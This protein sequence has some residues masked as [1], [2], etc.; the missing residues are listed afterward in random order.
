MRDN[1]HRHSLFLSSLIK[2]G[3]NVFRTK[4][5][6]DI[7]PAEFFR[8]VESHH[9]RIFIFSLLGRDF[10]EHLFSPSVADNLAEF[11]RRELK[12]QQ[13]LS[14]EL[15]R[16]HERLT[17]AGQELIVL[18]GPY[19]AA[20]F[21]GGLGRRSFA[22]LDVLVKKENW[23]AAERV[24]RDAKF[25]R[26]SSVMV[27]AGLT[28][29]F[30]HA[31]DYDRDGSTL[32]LH[33]SLSVHPSYHLDYR[34]IWAGKRE[35]EIDGIKHFVLSDDYEVTFLL[36][37]IFR[38]FERG[39]AKVKH[40]VDL[41]FVLCE[42]EA[43]I[44]WEEFFA[45]R[46]QE[47]TFRVSV[48]VLRVFFDLFACDDRFPALFAR[49]NGEFSNTG[50]AHSS[51][52]QLFFHPPPGAFKN[53]LSAMRIYETSL[54]LCAAWWLLSLPFRLSVYRPGHFRRKLRRFGENSARPR[55][56]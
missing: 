47:Q 48:F 5:R 31:F 54:P 7:P 10:C 17:R 13:I 23:R 43:F 8:F 52:Y 4:P 53:K 25:K 37:S 16:L 11:H 40:F 50:A 34:R 19:Y 45:R 3:E 27:T 55:Q 20:R 32:D 33:W 18:K 35:F 1:L 28:A 36:L 29:K 51:S 38:D 56:S 6:P 46:K 9:L 30:V 39:A 14:G 44:D 12:R 42:V 2:C 22:D 49:V 21:F 15:T 24:L 26:K 41:F